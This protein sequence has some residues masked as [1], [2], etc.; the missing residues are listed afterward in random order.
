MDAAKLNSGSMDTCC[1]GMGAMGSSEGTV[2]RRG[3]EPVH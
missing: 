1:D 3:R 2:R